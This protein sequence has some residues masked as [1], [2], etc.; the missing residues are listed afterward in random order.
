M[1]P[2][3]LIPA[4]LIAATLAACAQGSSGLSSTNPNSGSQMPQPANSL[5]PG[6]S[7]NAPIAGQTGVVGQAA[8]GSSTEMGEPTRTTVRRSTRRTRRSVR[9]ARARARTT[10]PVTAPATAPATAQ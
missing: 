7:V 1:S 4:L 5:P 6:D 2:F 9:R 8:V 10:A 3:K